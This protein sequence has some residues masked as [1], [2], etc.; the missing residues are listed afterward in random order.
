MN[1]EL[2][3]CSPH[4]GEGWDGAAGRAIAR[5]AER[6]RLIAS[7]LVEGVD[8]GTIP[9]CGDK[10]TLFKP[11]A[12]KITDALSLCPD[13]IVVGQTE[14]WEKRL[15]YYRYKCRLVIRGTET[16]VSTGIG[17]AN[18]RE[19]KWRYRDAQRRCP[20][21][22]ATAIIKGRPEYGGGWLCF[23]KRGGCGAKWPAG[24]SA[25]ESQALGKVENEDIETQ[26]NTIDKMAQ[27]RALVAACLNLGFSERFTQDIEDMH[28]ANDPPPTPARPDGTI[29][30]QAVMVG[31][32]DDLKAGTATP[33][34]T[35]SGASQAPAAATDAPE[36]VQPTQNAPPAAAT[37]LA[38]PSFRPED[39][40]PPLPT[41]SRWK[42]KPWSD[43]LQ[44]KAAR[45]LLHFLCERPDCP[46][47]MPA[48]ARAALDYAK[49]QGWYSRGANGKPGAD[50]AEGALADEAWEDRRRRCEAVHHHCAA[51]ANDDGFPG[52]PEW[53][54]G[55]C[56]LETGRG[57]TWD[58]FR[59]APSADQAKVLKKILEI[60][61]NLPVPF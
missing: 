55:L 17:S 32:N 20:K 60:E 24:A 52:F 8:Y 25:I 51:I 44:D 57:M 10:P 53:F 3:T 54:S 48:L 37:P 58:E 5:K 28:G 50:P 30:V 36:P 49:A 22:G 59:A 27:K 38:G 45:S 15:W 18:S 9:G 43:A 34:E 1:T 13:Y 56:A 2:A 33:P 19:N 47:W 41:L 35:P 11:G 12:E 42:G 4:A 29:D 40:V 26:I 16:V 23:G 31:L 6:D 7:V 46:P 14:D 61:K 39:P 21:C